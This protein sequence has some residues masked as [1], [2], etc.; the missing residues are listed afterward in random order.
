MPSGCGD[1]AYPGEGVSRTRRCRR[2]LSDCAI[3]PRSRGGWHAAGPRRVAP[4]G[5]DQG[6]ADQFGHRAALLARESAQATVDGLIQVELCPD[7]VMYVNRLPWPVKRRDA[8]R[9]FATGPRRPLERQAAIWGRLAGLPT[10]RREGGPGHGEDGDRV[11]AGNGQAAGRAHRAQAGLP[12]PSRAVVPGAA[13]RRDHRR[14]PARRQARGADGHRG[15][16]RRRHP[17]RRPAGP[18][19]R[20]AGRHRRA[21]AHRAARGAVHLGDEGRD[22][23]VRPRR[24]YGDRHHDGRDHVR[25][26][27]EVRGHGRLHLPARGGDRSAA[28]SR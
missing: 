3:D 8:S 20:L 17:P 19:D 9:S 2:C 5:S 14:A 21:A 6:V 7:H 1:G 15:D 22:A 13:H 12:P 28:P 18:H 24:A 26:P 10:A 11:V 16:R 4:V 23:R 25:A 27:R